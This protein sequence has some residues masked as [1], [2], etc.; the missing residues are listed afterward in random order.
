MSPVDAEDFN[1]SHGSFKCAVRTVVQQVCYLELLITLEKPHPLITIPRSHTLSYTIPR[2]HTL[3]YTI[4]RS[5]TLSYTIPRSHTLSYTIPRSHTLSYT[6]PRSHTLSYTCV[7]F[8]R[9]VRILTVRTEDGSC[10]MSMP[11]GLLTS[12]KCVSRRH[13]RSCHEA[14]SPE[15]EEGEGSLCSLYCIADVKLL[16]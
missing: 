6:I 3:S 2:S 1:C 15:G 10:L 7:H 11:R 5:H 14:P 8:P 12:R 16:M 9:C 13:S 4:P